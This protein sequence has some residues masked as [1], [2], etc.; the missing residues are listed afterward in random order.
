MSAREI[1]VT[2]NGFPIGWILLLLL[3]IGGL[4]LWA[5][6]NNNPAQPMMC[7]APGETCLSAADYVVVSPDGSM[8]FNVCAYHAAKFAQRGWS[9][10]PR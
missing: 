2:G 3:L 10:R 7:E 9:R 8:A 5:S 1:H 6:S 4:L